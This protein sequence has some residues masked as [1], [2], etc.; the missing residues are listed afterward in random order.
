MF[1]S[2]SLM[3]TQVVDS[4]PGEMVH[5]LRALDALV[6]DPGFVSVPTRWLNHL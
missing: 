6:E 1:K 5:Q 2:P 3:S 4:G